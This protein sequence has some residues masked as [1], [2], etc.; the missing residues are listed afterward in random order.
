[1]QSEKVLR[2][3]W[4]SQKSAGHVQPI[5]LLL[6]T[7]RHNNLL[8]NSLQ[9]NTSVPQNVWRGHIAPFSCC[10]LAGQLQSVF[11]PAKLPSISRFDQSTTQPREELCL[12]LQ[13]STY[14]F[15]CYQHSYIKR[16]STLP[17]K[18][19]RPAP[20]NDDC[21]SLSPSNCKANPFYLSL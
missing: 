18:M 20:M 9:H 1:M 19:K 12:F 14:I 13:T 6:Q 2:R 10:L 4:P 17:V 11:E 7:R 16:D 15:A 5:L 21:L 8:L 3:L